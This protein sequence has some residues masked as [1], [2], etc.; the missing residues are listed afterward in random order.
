[1]DAERIEKAGLNLSAARI[2]EAPSE[3]RL[4]E[5]VL[6]EKETYY[7][8]SN[9]VEDFKAIAEAVGLGVLPRWQR[10]RSSGPL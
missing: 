10:L 4:Q 8:Q 1:M 9:T 2:T 5:L 6:G 7:T 3:A